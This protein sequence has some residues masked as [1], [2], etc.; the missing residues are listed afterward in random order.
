M[1]VKDFAKLLETEFG[2]GL[3]RKIA[4]IPA[5]KSPDGTKKPIGE[6]NDWTR[7]EVIKKRMAKIHTPQDGMELNYSL[8][9]KHAP[10]LYCIDFDTKDFKTPDLYDML[11]RQDI[12]RTETKKGFHF[13]LKLSEELGHYSNELDVANTDLYHKAEDIDF[14]IGKRNMWEIA[15]RDVEGSSLGPIS[16]SD[17][18]PHLNETKMNFGGQTQHAPLPKA[19]SQGVISN[20][21]DEPDDPF[22]IV[23]EPKPTCDEATMRYYLGRLNQSRCDS[24][25]EHVRIGLAILHNFPDNEILAFQVWD[26][27][28]KGS[29]KYQAGG[30]SKKWQSL[31]KSPPPDDP[32]GPLSYRSIKG[33]ADKDDPQ[34]ELESLYKKDGEDAMVR[35]LNEMV[36]FREQFSDYIH[37]FNLEDRDYECKKKPDMKNHFETLE[38]SISE[39]DKKISPFTIWCKNRFRV[40]VHK[41]DFDPTNRMSNIFNLW[42]GYKIQEGIE[43]GASQPLC[44]HIKQV[45]CRQN[46]THYEYV[47]NWLAWVLQRPD[48]KNGVMISVKSR[49]GSGKGIVLSVMKMIMNGD[50]SKGPYSQVSNM[51]S[52]LN[53]TYGIEG[54]CLINLD[55]AFW[56]GDKKKE[57]QM[58]NL[59]TE[60]DQEIRKKH[61]PPYFITNTTAFITTTN[62]DYFSGMTA[63]DRRNFCLDGD[64]DFT[65][66]LPDKRGYFY[67]IAKAPKGYDPHPDV[68]NDFAYRL[69]N[70]DLS[71]F[72]PETFD[73]T[74][75]AQE[76]IQQGWNS[77]TRWWHTVL[78]D[79]VWRQEAKQE[80]GCKWAEAPGDIEDGYRPIP[81]R[82]IHESYKCYKVDGFHGFHEFYDEFCRRTKAII[83]EETMPACRKMIDGER[84]KVWMVPEDI[85]A[86]RKA[87]NKT[88]KYA[89]F[90]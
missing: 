76:Q 89:V 54:K 50:R 32:N 57:G 23:N 80:W 70:R 85:E 79:S 28:C 13:Y 29:D 56:G 10:G 17:I 43:S 22:V 49:Q 60:K 88:Q 53:W 25:D 90:T 87:F 51:D 84:V 72:D 61:Q 82:W 40:A 12:Y 42:N 5:D 34:N 67:N 41:V 11:V 68:V 86:M 8:Y 39:G 73:K 7:E 38:F 3:W 62:N 9:L 44:D 63:D 69:Y 2:E 55:E 48:R 71:H 15:T 47:L 66:A 77:V 74:S 36:I 37:V 30:Q 81:K 31:K 19:E 83:R 35:K 33:W 78:E 4:V 1:K 58:K 45:W 20:P 18:K 27:W 26:D 6:F 24:Y 52:I 16:Y 65:D 64:S 14:I 59:I 21:D 75:L 46:E